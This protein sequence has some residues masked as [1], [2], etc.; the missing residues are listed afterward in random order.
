MGDLAAWEVRRGDCIA[1]MRELDEASV[2][3]IVCDPP[4]GIGFMGKAW[5]GAAITEAAEHDRQNRRDLGPESSSRPGRA[6]P[7]SSS[8]Y[9]NEAIIAGPVRGGIAFQ[10]WCE[11]WASECLRILKPGGHLLAFGGTRTYH[12]LTAG[13]ED[14]GF[15]IRDTLCWLYGSG[16]PKSLDVSKAID[17]ASGHEREREAVQ[18]RASESS[19]IHHSGFG[20]DGWAPQNR[21][22]ITDE[23]RRWDGWGTALKPAHEPIVMARKP[24]AST[25]AANVLAHG[26][27]ALNIAGAR[28]EPEP[29]DY[30]HP[31]NAEPSHCNVYGF[32]DYD[33]LWTQSPPA[34][35]R[36]WPANLALDPEAAERLDGQAGESVAGADRGE[37]GTGGI[38]QPSSGVPCG[39]QYGDRGGS[40]GSSTL[41]RRRVPSVARGW[42]ASPIGRRTVTAAA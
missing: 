7:R 40:R 2:D 3:A 41:P 12:R 11:S 1:A 27:G 37:R 19:A 23:P 38:W 8:A 14:A 32:K 10:E 4:Y 31:G 29:G 26:T 35:G 24:L 16:F 15:E 9:G 13:I 36:R 6:Q 28:L 20:K 30:E 22:A 42:T 33:N 25:V 21:E 39:P 18:H 34:N 5:D 17:N